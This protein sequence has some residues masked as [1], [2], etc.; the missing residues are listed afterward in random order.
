M[1]RRSVEVV[2]KTVKAAF[3]LAV[4]RGQVV[5]NPAALVSVGVKRRV[6]DRPHWTPEQVGTFL[7]F[8]ATR[9]DIPNGLVEVMADTGAEPAKSPESDGPI[10]TSKPER[11]PSLTRSSLTLTTR[12]RCRSVRP[13]VR[14]RSPPSAC[15]R[16][17]WPP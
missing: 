10:S 6:T 5:R 15:I 14:A 4:D 2:H 1:S 17:P 8:A 9:K 11:S 13:S 7:A 3:K 12:R 16:R